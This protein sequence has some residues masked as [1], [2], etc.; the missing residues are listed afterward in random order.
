MKKILAI[1]LLA[2][3]LLASC[4]DNTP[5]VRDTLVVGTSQMEG[6]FSPF[7]YTNAYDNDII[8]LVHVNL[9]TQDRQ[10]SM[11]LSGIGGEVRPY[12]GTDYRYQGIADCQ[13]TDTP[14]G[15]QRYRFT[16]RQDVR[17]SDGELMDIDDVIFS[18]YVA[19][20]PSYD[21]IMTVYS[22]PILGLEE[23]RTGGAEFVTGIEKI[24][25]YTME[26]VL[27]EASASAV[28]TLSVA[29]TPLHYYGEE[30][31]YDFENHRFGFPK[32]DLSR[33]RQVTTKPMGAGP[34]VFEGF[35]NGVVRLRS[36]PNYYKGQPK[37]Q[38]LQ[39]RQGQDADKLSGVVAGTLD[40]ADPSYSLD[41]A[42]AIAKAN[43]GMLSGERI[44]T[45]LTDNLGYGY[46]G[47]H[48]KNVSV[49]GEPGSE[50]S[51]NLRKGL[52]TVIAA[53]R[54]V[55]VNSYYGSA[56]K[57]IEYP[58]S[59]TSWAAPR[60]TDPGYVRAFSQ[61]VNADPIYT[62][63]MTQEQRYEAAKKAALEYFVAAGYTQEN[64]V[65]TAAPAGASMEYEVLVSGGGTGDHPTF[66]CLSMA[67]RAL[68]EL[69]LSL[70]VTDLSNFSELNATVNGGAAQLYAMAWGA[71]A[72]PDM[73]QV[74]HSQGASNEKNYYV[75]DAQ[76]D[77]L[78]LQ[79]RQSS[80]QAFRKEIYRQCLDIIAQ[81]AVEVPVYQRQN[82]VIFATDRVNVDTLTRDM[83]PFWGWE[84]EI[85]QLALK[86]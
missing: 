7:F 66:M 85:E 12:L 57:V 76:L 61:R 47:I 23:Y 43:G 79:A 35:E 70:Y 16:L 20:D 34:Y 82:A 68:Q 65:L 44:T 67:S 72:D 40:I 10:G 19:V 73:F 53:Y 4:G 46:I 14:E 38:N 18:M 1:C 41:T 64:G 26:V 71:S 22:L 84:Q 77:S 63:E 75:K 51:K 27:T 48:A 6:K 24:D 36:N 52:A 17:F 33:V 13:I 60:A 30:E 15:H 21:G 45:T 62:E 49:G 78:I 54:D 83:T 86:P 31:Q 74:Y 25:Q 50:A 8:S 28:Y 81:W 56:A 37:I 3:V 58:I 55:A 80:D 69:G 59:N 39:F 29:V 2:A 9:L 42:D 11:V 5:A 32:G